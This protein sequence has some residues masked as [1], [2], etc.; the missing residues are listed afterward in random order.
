[1]SA[2]AR[3]TAEKPGKNIN[4]SP[5]LVEIVRT[6]PGASLPGSSNKLGWRGERL[7]KVN[8]AYTSQKC[9]ACGYTH[10]DNR[11]SQAAFACL[12]W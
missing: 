1:M 4:T 11:K 10:A 3:G 5:R 9:G 12:G 7:I 2:S 6:R 8:P